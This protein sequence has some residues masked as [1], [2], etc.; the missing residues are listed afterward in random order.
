MPTKLIKNSKPINIAF[1]V[2]YNPFQ[3]Q[4]QTLRIEA[5]DWE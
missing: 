4:K 1:I 3:T 5:G 2:L